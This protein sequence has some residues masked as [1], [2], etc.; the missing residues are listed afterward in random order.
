MKESWIWLER[1]KLMILLKDFQKKIG[2]RLI[3]GLYVSTINVHVGFIPGVRLEAE[4]S[5]PERFLWGL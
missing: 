3:Y 4:L 1:T 5:H 2:A